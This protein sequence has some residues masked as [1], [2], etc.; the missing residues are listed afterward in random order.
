MQ[1]LLRR[2]GVLLIALFVVGC[3]SLPSRSDVEEL[4]VQQKRGSGVGAPDEFVFCDLRGG[5]WACESTS[6]KTALVSGAEVKPAHTPS[7]SIQKNSPVV[8]DDAGVPIVTVFFDFNK[9]SIS[10]EDE[11]AL[12]G[13]VPSLKNSKR[14][15]VTGYTDNIGSEKYNGFLAQRR[16]NVVKKI[17]VENGIEAGV[18]KAFGRGMCC[19]IDKNSDEN[20][21]SKNRRST[22]VKL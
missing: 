19:Y 5:A 21:R 18:V 13:A 20:G 22:V 14:I 9:A 7:F 2:V 12:I 8:R 1:G 10:T 3:E 16:A 17:L 15:V 4:G 11:L 6:V